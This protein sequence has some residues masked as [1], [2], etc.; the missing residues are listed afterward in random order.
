MEIQPYH[1][2]WDFTKADWMF[3]LHGSWRL[4]SGGF[5]QRAVISWLGKTF[6]GYFALVFQNE[7][8]Q[9]VEFSGD[10]FENSYRYTSDWHTFSFFVNTLTSAP[11][12]MLTGRG[13]IDN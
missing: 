10:I 1:G 12:C 3:S 6:F 2:A 7:V 13:V 11:Q 8:L 4:D 9:Y 5:K